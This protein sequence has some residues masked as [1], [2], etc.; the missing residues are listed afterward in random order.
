MGNAGKGPR[1]C[2]TCGGTGCPVCKGSG[3][4][5][6]RVGRWGRGYEQQE[7]AGPEEWVEREEW[8]D[9]EEWAR[10]DDEWSPDAPTPGGVAEPRG[11]VLSRL[12]RPSL[13]VVAFAVLGALVLWDGSVVSPVLGLGGGFVVGVVV[14]AL[15]RLVR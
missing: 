3:V 8:T 12:L 2:P 7:Q 15:L 11:G 10:P 4:A 13:A 1:P 9:P 14:W 5:S 6:Q